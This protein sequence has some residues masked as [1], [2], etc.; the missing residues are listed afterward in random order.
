MVIRPD[1]RLGSALLYYMLKIDTLCFV[2]LQIYEVY[3]CVYIYTYTTC[4]YVY[5]YTIFMVLG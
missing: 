2:V 3:V 4:I 1:Y 5:M